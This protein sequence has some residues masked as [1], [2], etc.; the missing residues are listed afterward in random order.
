[1]FLAILSSYLE[2]EKS[3]VSITMNMINSKATFFKETL[4]TSSFHTLQVEH[5][6]QLSFMFLHNNTCQSRAYFL[7][8]TS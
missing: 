3:G 6:S 5:K 1:M 4:E 8:P 2:E 7:L